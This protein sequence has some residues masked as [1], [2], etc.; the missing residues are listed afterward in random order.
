MNTAQ[1]QQSPPQSTGSKD[2]PWMPRVWDGMTAWVW[3]SL[4]ARNRFAISLPCIAMAVVI[5]LISV[6]N[7]LLW[8]LQTI[9]YGRKIARTH[10]SD[11]PIF[12]IGHWRSGTTLLHEFWC[13]TSDTPIPT[14]TSASRPNH[15]LVSGW[16]LRPLL[17]LL[18]PKRRPMDNMEFGWDRPQEDEF[19]LCSMGEGTPY[20]TIA[21]PNRPP[22]DQEYFDLERLT[23]R[24]VCI[25]AANVVV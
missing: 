10:I 16:L 15:F 22:Q 8:L 19:A 21:F 25:E 24:R 11:D 4:L 20:R 12:V 6:V 23:P 9:I 14:P 7:T 3:F 1:K 13:W 5:S 2:R 18:L 17:W